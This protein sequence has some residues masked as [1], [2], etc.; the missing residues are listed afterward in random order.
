MK[1]FSLSQLTA[2]TMVVSVGLMIGSLLTVSPTPSQAAKGGGGKTGDDTSG[3][4]KL[5]STLVFR[6]TLTPANP[7][8]R[9]TSDFFLSPDPTSPYV[10][11]TPDPGDVEVFIGSSAKEGD[12]LMKLPNST[13]RINLDFLDLIGDPAELDPDCLPSVGV[14]RLGCGGSWLT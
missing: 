9:I 7:F 10:D 8:D 14:T 5:P 6:D 11:N 2:A 4:E 1:R 3:N 12:I 13:R